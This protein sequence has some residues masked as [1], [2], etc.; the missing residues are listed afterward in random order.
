MFGQ[1]RAL[2]GVS[3]DL[4]PGS[5]HALV[6]E[7]GAGK[8]TLMNVLYG[9]YHPDAGEIWLGGR[10]VVFRGP[11]DAI[12]AGIGMVH[13]HFMLVPSLTVAENVVLGAEPRRS[14]FFDFDRACA[15]VEGTCKRFSFALD[16]RARVEDLTIGSQQK[17]EIVKA[18][19]RGAKILILDEPTAVLTPQET[20]ELFRVC[21]ALANAGHTLVLI[22]HKLREVLAVA[23]RISVMR[24]GRHICDLD[25][26]EASVERLAE[27]MVGDEGRGTE[28]TVAPA[29]EAPRGPPILEARELFVRGPSAKPL[30]NRSSL[31]VWG[32]EIVGVAG[33]DGNGQRELA[34]VLT[35]LRP[36]DGGTVTLLGER[37]VPLSPAALRR[38]GV[39]HIPED[40]FRRAMI[41][42]MTLEENLS[43]GRQAESPFARNGWIDFRGRRARAEALIRD[44][45]I[46]PP[47]P[48]S[49]ASLLSGGNQ[50]KAVVARELDMK[51]RLLVVV[52]PTRGL[53]IAAVSLVHRRLCDERARG[54][55]VLLVSLDLDEV[56]S[57][58]DRIYVFFE[59][60]I[61]AEVSRP[62]FDERAIGRWMLG[63][64]H[65]TGEEVARA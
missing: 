10:R 22:S 60:T 63:G 6:G 18:L 25:A 31:R 42:T 49:R 35:G 28:P 61:A 4:T 55:G 9:L 24:R 37:V 50:Q 39:A 52:Q 16:P 34:E 17:V 29:R 48:E 36:L 57:L 56:L 14:I 15:E 19:H 62:E 23:R 27:L 5:I 54:T 41:G 44:F 53:D 45:D 43:L 38:R 59:G 12:Q 65:A 58:S 51:P 33:V 46:R 13:Q 20:D 64:A 40:R 8:T 30:L 1:V 21:R 2:D 47:L 11:R 3:L 32:G 7:N 26:Q